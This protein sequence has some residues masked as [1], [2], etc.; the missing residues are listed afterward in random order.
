LELF[1][2]KSFALIAHSQ[3]N[4]F[5][6]VEQLKRKEQKEV[7]RHEKELKALGILE[8]NEKISGIYKEEGFDEQL[9]VLLSDPFDL[10][11]T[12]E[13]TLH[14]RE[15][16]KEIESIVEQQHQNNNKKE[17]HVHAKYKSMEKKVKPV[18]TQLPDLAYEQVQKASKDPILRNPRK[19]G[20]EFTLESLAKVKIGGGEFLTSCEQ[21]HF[22]TMIQRHG[23]AFA[24]NY[25]EIGCVDPKMITPMVIFTVPH[26]PW[27]L[28]PI[29]VPKA[30]VPKIVEML[31]EKIKVGILEP[32]MG[33]YSSRWFTVPKKSGAL[34]FI[35]DLQPANKVTIR[36][37][38]S[39]PIVDDVAEAFAGCA[40]YSIGDLFSGYDQ[41]Q[42]SIESRDITTMRT[43]LGLVR[44]C[45]LPQGA[46][47]S[48]AHMQNAMNTILREFIPD[49]TIP[50]VDD[51][52]M[53]GCM[54]SSK[55]EELVGNGCRKFVA[56][57]IEDVERILARLEESNLT[58]SAEKSSFGVSE[59][60]V[61]GHLC[62]PYGRR[63]N[64][65]K[66][67]VIQLMKDCKNVTEVRRFLGACLFFKIWIPHY[68]HLAEPLYCLLRKG[69]QFIWG[70]QQKKAMTVLKEALQVPPL[71]RKID[72]TEGKYIILTVDTSP[73]AIG[74]AVGQ[75]D[76][77]G[78]R[79][80][81]R[82]GARVLSETQRNYPQI[83]R[84][85]WGIVT[86]MK[87][88]RE[89]LIG[90]RI[91]VETDCLPLLGMIVNCSTPDIAMLR[92]IAY[93]RSLNPELCHIA[94]KDNMVADMLSRAR[95]KREADLR[96]AN[97]YCL[98][99]NAL[100]GDDILTFHEDLYEG[101]MLDIGHYLSTLQKRATWSDRTFK[102]IR[103]KAYGFCLQD[104]YLWKRPKRKDGVPLRVV[105]DSTTKA[106]IL[107]EYH[108]TMWAGH[109]GIWATF[110]KLKERY[111]WKGMYKDV[112]KFVETCIPCQLQSK[113]Q[114]R[115]GLRPTYPLCIHFQWVI[116]LVAM[117]SG[118]WGMRYLVL[119]RE[120][121]SNFVE[122]RALRT[123]GTEQV[124]RFILEDIVAR[125]G[126]IGN[127]RAD[128]GELNAEEAREFFLR[129]GIHLRLTTAMNPQANGKSERGHP[130]IIQALV[131]A[132]HGNHMDWP[133]LLPFALWADRTTHSSVTGYMPYEL[134][135]GQKPLMP[136]ESIISTWVT[137]PW[138]DHLSREE[139]LALRMRQ[140]ER[141]SE[142]LEDAVHKLREAR[143]KN[144]EYFDKTY[145]LRPTPIHEG[146]WVLV[147]DSSLDHQHS[148]IR[149]FS[150][151]WF[152]PYVVLTVFDNATYS[153]RE[154]DG[155][156]LKT[157]IA[158]KRIKI[159]R[160][161]NGDICWE[162]LLAS[163][164]DRVLSSEQD[165]QH[166]ESMDDHDN[167]VHHSC[168]ILCTSWQMS[169][170]G[171]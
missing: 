101:K 88:E 69:Q 159:F 42:L 62:G 90:A 8:D 141:R 64:P 81:T 4:Q 111:W 7:A 17:V 151:R 79:F 29:P 154:L 47:N 60:T 91:K 12:K 45:T 44:M 128:R 48:V 28:K 100:S 124:C 123:K 169:T 22:R 97:E 55:N 32:S 31:K 83:K 119:A 3:A 40:I 72:Y 35:Q 9:Q 102:H 56:D 39:G 167:D 82:F 27:D 93:I 113:A 59:I 122:G 94:G 15:I 157:R 114:H 103:Q 37:M 16:Y 161:R 2:Q 149:K 34:R 36:N 105:G 76:A 143:L 52:P 86:A 92:W 96:M 6:Q 19:I 75:D 30:M 116:D 63:P 138:E 118:L 150:R 145:R 26:V 71:L 132:C 78:L 99:T 65:L 110:T 171:G 80:A 20:H 74:W 104:G 73:L 61:V 49:K 87:M 41:F 134:M 112:E 53:K 125:Y 98:R 85:L 51:L 135:L 67:N 152:G 23:K 77:E 21:D 84:E 140:L 43:P 146:D 133:R 117:P 168:G 107:K 24:F 89:Y 11:V 106:T 164:S 129:Y 137:L 13:I 139:L 10:D 54:V 5:Q 33:P 165:E 155:T 158:G 95:Y 127:M 58:L 166:H 115:D 120:E 142:D 162:D 38:G 14:S 66:V 57:H 70:D 170:N 160:R 68:G 18:A 136:V 108:D 144:K 46:T 163:Y 126:S 130:P 25:D 148:T 131:K 121:L 1:D 156:P 147:H 50:F 153:L 109:R